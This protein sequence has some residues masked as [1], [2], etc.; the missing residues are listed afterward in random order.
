MRSREKPTMYQCRNGN[1]MRI[2]MTEGGVKIMTYKKL[3]KLQ[4]KC[5]TATGRKLELR[6][7]QKNLR[8]QIFKLR[9][10][11]Q[12]K[13]NE[14]N[15]NQEKTNEESSMSQDSSPN[16]GK[17]KTNSNSSDSSSTEGKFIS[18]RM[19]RRI[20]R[21][22][23]AKKNKKCRKLCEMRKE[24]SIN[25][26]QPNNFPGPQNRMTN[27]L[28]NQSKCLSN[29]VQCLQKNLHGPLESLPNSNLPTSP[30][31]NLPNSNLPTSPL[32]NFPG[33]NLGSI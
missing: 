14:A 32:G 6:S 25:Q 8:S 27:L 19:L 33:F 12:E 30:L 22:N 3:L 29:M 7:C 23:R 21:N 17:S 31:G 11:K 26:G 20:F 1:S 5:V 24:P 9:P 16:Q 2:K 15:L 10:A 28:Q 18:N 13:R 4:E